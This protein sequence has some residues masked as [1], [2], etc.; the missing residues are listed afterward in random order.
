MGCLPF[1]TLSK[2]YRF[3]DLHHFDMVEVFC[4]ATNNLSKRIDLA[5]LDNPRFSSGDYAFGKPAGHIALLEDEPSGDEC[6]RWGQFT[7]EDI[8]GDN[9]SSVGIRISQEERERDD[10]PGIPAKRK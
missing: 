9:M 6:A 10:G 8:A 5:F 3:L 2:P 7:R 4:Q 1:G